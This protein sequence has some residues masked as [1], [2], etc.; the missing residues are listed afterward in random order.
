MPQATTTAA[1]RIVLGLMDKP[2]SGMVAE[3]CTFPVDLIK[4]RLQ[5][6]VFMA[7]LAVQECD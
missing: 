1:F 4:T 7:S 5:L 2:I 3:T 6:Q